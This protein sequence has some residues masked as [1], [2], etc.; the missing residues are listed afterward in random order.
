MADYISEVM[1][2]GREGAGVPYGVY[3]DKEVSKRIEAERMNRL[4][5][6]A[7]KQ[8][9]LQ[10]IEDENQGKYGTISSAPV[11][12]P[13]RTG[14]AAFEQTAPGQYLKKQAQREAAMFLGDHEG[15]GLPPGTKMGAV[16]SPGKIFSATARTLGRMTPQAVKKAA[17]T[18]VDDIVGNVRQSHLG[19]MVDAI[20]A[21]AKKSAPHFKEAGKQAAK[22]A[23]ET[24]KK[25][26][27]RAKAAKKFTSKVVD[28]TSEVLSGT[29]K[30]TA[31]TARVAKATG[32][33]TRKIAKQGTKNRKGFKAAVK[34]Q[35]KAKG[36]PLTRIEKKKVIENQR[37]SQGLSKVVTKPR[38]R[39]KPQFKPSKAK[40]KP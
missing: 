30:G 14:I 11:T 8:R 25:T 9:E 38:K 40:P 39:M 15:A 22:G 2:R 35:E 12:E 34:A 13:V 17:K 29:P 1:S 24:I 16:P 19:P 7:A 6:Q 27:A 33:R 23:R 31:S 5:R 28:R 26:P 32:K 18:T 4:Q 3:S 36:S 37:A 21:G 10:V 20:S